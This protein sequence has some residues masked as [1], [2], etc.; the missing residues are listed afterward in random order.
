M[1]THRIDTISLIPQDLI[2][3]KVAEI[4]TIKNKKSVNHPNIE[5]KGEPDIECKKEIVPITKLEAMYRLTKNLRQ[6]TGHRFEVYT[7][8]FMMHI[9]ILVCIT[10]YLI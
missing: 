9:F 7:E 2:D 4:F 5:M 8:G 3:N 10:L 6:F 1:T